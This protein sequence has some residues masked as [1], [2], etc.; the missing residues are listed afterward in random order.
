MVAASSR[1]IQQAQEGRARQTSVRKTIDG[2][3]HTRCGKR[4][5]NLLNAIS[6]IKQQKSGLSN[7][8]EA[9]ASR[10]HSHQRVLSIARRSDHGHCVCQVDL[11]SPQQVIYGS[12]VVADLRV[13]MN[14]HIA[15]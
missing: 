3:R 7:E 4:S 13:H 1:C 8:S 2:Q 9:L 14:A 6:D 15:A 11:P 12:I 5:A 10:C